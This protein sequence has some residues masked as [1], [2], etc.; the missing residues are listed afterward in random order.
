MGSF[1][2]DN[3]VNI[4]FGTTTL[5]T[6]GIALHYARLEH[7]RKV[8]DV[9]YE[10]RRVG[11]F[12]SR[13]SM[14]RYLLQMY[15]Q[16]AAGDVIWAQCVR[17]ANFTPDVRPQISKAAGRGV[18]FRMIINQYSPSLAAFRSLF[19]PIRQAEL[20]AA[21]DNA[22]SLQGLSDKELVVAFPGVE[23]YTAVL[24]R[25]PY[26][27]GIVRRWFDSRFEQLVAAGEVRNGSRKKAFGNPRSRV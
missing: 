1:L 25:D 3:I 13:E 19:A 10:D 9:L 26:F 27:V 2:A 21:P 22:L 4:V 14:I 16:A 24:I 23:S 5:V 7:R 6:T 20:A 17:C 8:E 18:R 11:L 15:D 12:L